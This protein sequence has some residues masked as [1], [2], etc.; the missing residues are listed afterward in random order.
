[1]GD[2]RFWGHARMDRR[3]CCGGYVR[4]RTGDINIVGQRAVAAGMGVVGW[5]PLERA[6]GHR[7]WQA[8]V[9]VGLYSAFL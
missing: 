9:G 7:G 3:T 1:M 6:A 4:S 8:T 5:P 2:D